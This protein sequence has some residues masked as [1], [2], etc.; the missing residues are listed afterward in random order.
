MNLI[1]C[2][3]LKFIKD[4]VKLKDHSIIKLKIMLKLQNNYKKFISLQNNTV[5]KL[6]NIIRNAIERRIRII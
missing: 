4:A 2:L 6:Q 3:L 1:Y 5:N